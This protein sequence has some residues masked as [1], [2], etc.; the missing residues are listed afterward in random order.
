MADITQNLLLAEADPVDRTVYTTSSISPG[1]NKLI[2]CLVSTTDNGLNEPI[3]VNSITG[4]GLTWVKITQ[5]QLDT[6]AAPRMSM[7]VF[8]ALG[9]SPSP[10]SLTIT[11]DRESALT[12]WIIVEF[13]NVD[14]GGADGA[15]AVVQ[16]ANNVA[17][18]GTSIAATLAA[19]GNENNATV[20]CFTSS[21]NPPTWT[22]GS[23]FAE[24]AE[25]TGSDRTPMMEFRADN[26]VSVDATASQDADIAVIGIELKNADQGEPPAPTPIITGKPSFIA[27]NLIT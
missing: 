1:A 17:D 26:D 16:F 22:P 12:Q 4:T 11:L 27:G 7:A 14:T 13:D 2:L 8:G 20:G 6:I 25:A 10:G 24:I 3:L 5:V 23:G 18:S 15:D 19:F 21:G 9:P